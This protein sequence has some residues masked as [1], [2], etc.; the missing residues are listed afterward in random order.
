MHSGI[1]TPGAHWGADARKWEASPNI[2]GRIE[3]PT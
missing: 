3:S 2:G 1:E